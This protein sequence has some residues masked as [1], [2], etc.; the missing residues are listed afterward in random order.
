MRRL[1]SFS[2]LVTALLAASPAVALATTQSAH[3]GAVSA[4]FTFAGTFP[5]FTRLQ[6]VIANSGHTLYDRPVS[7]KNCGVPYCGP[8]ESGP[9]QSSVHV[10]DLESNGRPDVV[11][12][13]FT[14][15]AHCCTIEQVFSFD[16]RKHTYVKTERNFGDPGAQIRDLGH[17]GRLEFLTADDSF[18]GAFTSYAGS[19]LPIEILTFRGGRF[20]DVTRHYPGRIRADAAIWWSAFRH[21][22]GD[23]VGL[24]AAW[25][26][27]QDL[28]GREALVTRS[29]DQQ[30]R[31][32]H[33]RSALGGGE[34][35]GMKFVAALQRFLRAHGYTRR[36]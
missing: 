1:L 32:G 17:N 5:K 13:L 31:Q 11:L 14:E 4:R 18:A 15:G 22:L 35:S 25:A 36:S 12:D 33:L 2:W 8:A 27:D 34:P 30:A 21:N 10:L 29:L 28:L 19:G 7:A 24:I 9:H 16:P 23:G 3:S 6:L 26:A 20:T